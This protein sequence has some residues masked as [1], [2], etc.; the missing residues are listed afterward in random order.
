MTGE[1]GRY[2]V[3]GVGGIGSWLVRLLAPFLSYAEPGATIF[4]VDGDSFEEANRSRM[5][6]RL[7]G[8][9]AVVLAEELAELYGDRIHLVPIPRFISGRNA[10]DLITEGDVVFAQPDNH[11][12]RRVVERRC[13]RLANVALFSGG[14]DD[15]A[16]ESGGSFGNVQ[17][18]IRKDGRNVTNPISTFHPEIARPAD[19]V[20]NAPGCAA[21]TASNPQILFT[22]AAVASALLSLFY[23]WRVGRLDY[24]EVY[25]DILAASMTSVRRDLAGARRG[26]RRGG[27]VR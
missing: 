12:T 17:A 8:P 23:T 11:A 24:E 15:A 27:G 26:P 4:L 21:A 20:P 9:K 2:D 3:I 25:L 18:Y 7:P 13:M 5:A 16:D 1:P 10:R 19:R 14:N 6:F 22:N